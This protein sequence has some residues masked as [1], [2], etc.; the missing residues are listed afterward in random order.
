MFH[1]FKKKHKTANPIFE[2]LGTDI[3]C[4]LLPRVDDG[5]KSEEE[6][7]ICL[8]TMKEAGFQNVVL[9]PH[10]QFP[11]FPNKE[12]DILDRYDT[13]KI[14][15]ASKTATGDIPDLVGIAGEYRV[16]SGFDERIKSDEFLRVADRFILAEFS[17]HQQVLGLEE[18][19]YELQNNNHDVIIAHPE[20]YPYFSAQS[21]R[22]ETLKNMGVYFQVNILSLLGFY[23]DVERRKGF[24][25]IDNGW[26]EFL[27]TDLHNFRYA[28][29]LI[30]STHDRKIIKLLERKTFLNR[31][32]LNP[33]S[34]HQKK[35]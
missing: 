13:F 11:R 5:A 7:Y 12:S 14:D 8:R 34:E 27:G 25:L 32:L 31:E 30:D 21:R 35:I 26:V 15:M 33:E 23:G 19:I 29:A 10:Y 2:A 1:F 18:K 28:Q 22:L 20:R 24:E 16:D 4:H 9:T 17:L 6:S 3:H